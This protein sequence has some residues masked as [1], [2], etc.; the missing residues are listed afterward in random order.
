MILSQ[1][2]IRHQPPYRYF[3]SVLGID[4]GTTSIS[5]SVVDE[6]TGEV[7]KKTTVQNGAFIKSSNA[8][9][10]IQDPNE[11]LASVN[12]MIEASLRE[13]TTINAIGLT[14]QMHGILYV[15]SQGE[16]VSPLY[17]WQDERGNLD[18]R[19]GVSYAAYLSKLTG[20]SL[21]T[22]FGLV[23]HFFN[24]QNHLVPNECKQICTISDYCA[25]KLTG[26]KKALIHVS[27]AA[28][29][30]IFNTEQQ[31]FDKK[32]VVKAGISCD[33][34]PPVV[35]EIKLV[36]DTKG[37]IPVAIAIGD[38]QASFLGAVNDMKDSVLVNIGT[39]SQLSLLN[40]K[41]Y[42]YEEDLE[43]RPLIGDKT[44]LVGA[45]L[46]GGKSYELLEKFFES[47]LKM[48]DIP[49]K[50]LFSYMN[51]INCT[52]FEENELPIITPKFSGTRK[53]PNLQ[54]SITNINNHNFT[55]QHFILAMLEG[56]TKEL[57]DLYACIQTQQ[58]FKAKRL[59][60]SGNGIR[61]NSLLRKFLSKTFEL[62]LKVP[63]YD[64]E[65][66]YGACLFALVGKGYFENIETAQKIIKYE[67]ED[68]ID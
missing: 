20:Y 65:A 1:G 18:Y 60:G 9:E 19:E 44:I 40:D 28:S 21:A 34:L 57:F 13:F 23:T 26:E 59:I 35:K 6:G 68:K 37:A 4:I 33:L 16:S 10:K 61:K 67:D 45:P 12:H 27:N 50:N 31:E 11:I 15:D 14:G 17:I 46:C 7:L 2:W 52:D 41:S 56:I 64:E 66:A 25:M 32:A 58:M 24:M 39:G 55:A 51:D 5:A 62:E 54:A 42:S 43:V 22:G 53:N 38:N 3:M 48:A 36:G 29:L 49:I 63:V 8:W 47:V 30:G